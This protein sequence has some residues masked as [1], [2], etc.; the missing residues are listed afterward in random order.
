[1]FNAQR[2]RRGVFITLL[3]SQ[4][5]APLQAQAAEPLSMF[6]LKLLRDQAISAGIEN[7]VTGAAV[8]PPA[9]LTNVYGITEEQLRGLIDEGFVHLTPAQRAEVYSSLTRILTDPKNAPARP[10]II[11]EL[12]VQASI[13]RGTLERLAALTSAER[14]AIVADAR[15][16]YARLPG[17]DRDRL[18]R[19]LQARVAPIPHD[20]NDQILAAILVSP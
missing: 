15:A 11:E 19:L 8:P 1:M 10:L 7:A 2:V 18:V 3:L 17:E 6:L 20:L 13:V 4:A 16:E 9:P 14:R 12:A 5:V